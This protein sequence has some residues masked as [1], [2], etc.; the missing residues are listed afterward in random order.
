MLKAN[1]NLS[2]VGSAINKKGPQVAVSHTS[3]MNEQK[4]KHRQ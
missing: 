1:S 4:G 2:T 3:T